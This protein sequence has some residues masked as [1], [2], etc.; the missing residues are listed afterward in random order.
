MPIGEEF[1]F[2]SFFVVK[3][4]E[5]RSEIVHI[6]NAAECFDLPS[7]PVPQ[8]GR[9]PRPVLPNQLVLRFTFPFESQVRLLKI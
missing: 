7:V 3:S 2:N 1:K 6:L 9:S 5:W 4:Q 8:N